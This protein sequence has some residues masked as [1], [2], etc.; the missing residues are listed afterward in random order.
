MRSTATTISFQRP[1]EIR[2]EPGPSDIRA[3]EIAVAWTGPRSIPWSPRTVVRP[4]AR[5]RLDEW[6]MLRI[7]R[8]KTML[9]DAVD[10]DP[11]LRDGVLV[12]RG[13]RFPVSRLLAEIADD[14]P[15][16]EVAE[17]FDLDINLLRKLLQAMAVCFERPIAE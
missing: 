10:V 16:S 17:D 4:V 2:W 7:S 6:I 9:H 11:S 13:T 1:R 15:V 5:R 3:A 14:N 8:A 12:L